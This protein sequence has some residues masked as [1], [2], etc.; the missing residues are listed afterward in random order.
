MLFDAVAVKLLLDAVEVQLLAAPKTVTAV[1]TIIVAKH[2][3]AVALW[4]W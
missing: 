1:A 2:L 3:I 4:W